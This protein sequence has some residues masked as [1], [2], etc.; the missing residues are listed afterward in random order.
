LN[1]RDLILILDD[2]HKI[3]CAQSVLQARKDI[4]KII[5]GHD[6]GQIEA[7][8]KV[9]VTC[10]ESNSCIPLATEVMID[11][12][13]KTCTNKGM[14]AM[15]SVSTIEREQGSTPAEIVPKTAAL[16]EF[17]AG[18]VRSMVQYN[19]DLVKTFDNVDDLLADLNSPE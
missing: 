2:G 11:Y 12:K 10:I 1:S 9:H 17:K 8:I 18:I 7:S 5:C 13:Y 6:C 3:Q 14:M 16:D 4:Y 15:D 19:A